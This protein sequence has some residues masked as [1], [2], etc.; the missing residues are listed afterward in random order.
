MTINLASLLNGQMFDLIFLIKTLD[1]MKK[2]FLFLILLSPIMMTAQTTEAENK[3]KCEEGTERAKTDFNKGIRKI[4]HFGLIGAGQWGELMRQNGITVVEKGCYVEK[5]FEC[6]NAYMKMKI[7]QEK[8]IGFFTKIDMQLKS[9]RQ[10]RG[11]F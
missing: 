9:P 5:E 7:E 6:Y 11:I 10:L 8:G 1:K 2:L 4:Y 3:E